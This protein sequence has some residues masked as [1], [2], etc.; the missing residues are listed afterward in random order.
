MP[1]RTWR[2]RSSTTCSFALA[3]ASAPSAAASKR[4]RL[5]CS[6]SISSLLAA[7]RAAASSIRLR[8]PELSSAHAWRSAEWMRSSACSCEVSCAASRAM[9]ARTSSASAAKVL[10]WLL[11]DS[12]S[13][14]KASR[15]EASFVSSSRTDSSVARRCL[16]CSSTK[17]L[18]RSATSRRAACTR[19]WKLSDRAAA[20]LRSCLCCSSVR[21]A[22]WTI[23]SS[24]VRKPRSLSASRTWRERCW[25]P[26]DSRMAE[27][28]RWRSWRKAS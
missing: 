17:P 23:I 1:S 19:T 6:C 11:Q 25:P 16:A 10:L 15:S 22:S 5:R 3:S 26:A 20:S 13:P 28:L 4:E 27:S 2:R 9:R 12:P 18:Q 7:C 21:E 8:R 24:L 14:W